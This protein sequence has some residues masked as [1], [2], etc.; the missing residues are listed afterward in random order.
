MRFQGQAEEF[1]FILERLGVSQREVARILGI[2]QRTFRKY[3]AG[4]VRAPNH[5]RLGLLGIEFESQK[6]NGDVNEERV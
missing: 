4:T 5:I 1:H 2:P 6:R 3:V